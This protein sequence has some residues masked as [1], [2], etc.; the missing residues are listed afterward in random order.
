ML[1]KKL[2]NGYIWKRIFYERITEPLHLNAISLPIAFLGGLRSRIA[3]DLVLRCQHAYSI[4][5]CA[6]MAAAQGLKKVTLIEFGVA[7]GAGLLN[8]CEVAKKVTNTTGI[9]FEIFGFD[10]GQGMPAPLSYRDHP[11]LYQQGDYPMQFESLQKRLPSNAKLI[12]GEIEQTYPA[13]LEEVS[14]AAPVGFVSID[15]DYY[16]STKHA[17]SVLRGLPEQYLPR[18][19]V[20]LDDLEDESHNSY[21]GELLAV[22]EFNSD[23]TMRKIERHHFLRSY[24]IFKNARWIDHIFVCHVLDHATRNLLRQGRAAAVLANPYL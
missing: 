13:F 16:S 12:L 6:D 17:L 11:E 21:C 20:Y 9:E 1:F 2:A 19:L 7:A 23:Q 3:W 8:I 14:A 22:N 24:R 10:T 18:V 15:V 5:K 4:L